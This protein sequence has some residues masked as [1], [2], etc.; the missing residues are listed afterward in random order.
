[1]INFTGIVVLWNEARRLRDCLNSLSF[2]EQLIVIDSGSSDAS[3]K[4]AKEF[5]AEVYHYEKVPVVE[6]IHEMAVNNYARNEWFIRIDPDEVLPPNLKEKLEFLI[7]KEPDL[8]TIRIPWQFYVKGKPLYETI[9]GK[10][11]SKPVVLNKSRIKFNPYVH[12]ATSLLK[13]YRE[14]T[15]PRNNDCY[16]Q[17]YWVD[18]YR[19]MVQK[20]W[21]Y[22]GKEGEARYSRGERFSV[23]KL[24][25]ATISAFKHSLITCNG[26]RNFTGIF[27]SFFYSWYVLMGILS[28][29]QYQKVQK[30]QNTT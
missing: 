4:I 14:S 9:W 23:Y 2:C 10:N 1:M 21:I 15:L 11:N 13:G 20:H 17:H 22:I 24:I 6:K 16:I 28:L 27:L 3:I 19:E 25:S 12:G 29:W 5:G 18:S 7:N 26:Y 8:G 30:K